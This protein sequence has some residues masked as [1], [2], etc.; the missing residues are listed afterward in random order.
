MTEFPA[1]R[2]Q[3]VPTGDRR[4]QGM[5][6]A[7]ILTHNPHSGISTWHL[8]LRPGIE[9]PAPGRNTKIGLHHRL[10]FSPAPNAPLSL[11]AY[12]ESMISSR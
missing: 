2:D 12:T 7:E 9:V 6:D 4:Y 3:E 11:R 1:E 5:D 8:V 10:K